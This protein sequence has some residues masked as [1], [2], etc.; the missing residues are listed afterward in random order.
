MKYIKGVMIYILFCFSSD[1]PNQSSK[2]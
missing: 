1:N 2:I